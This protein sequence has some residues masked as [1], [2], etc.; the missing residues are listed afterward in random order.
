MKDDVLGV[1]FIGDNPQ[2][3]RAHGPRVAIVQAAGRITV[4]GGQSTEAVSVFRLSVGRLRPKPGHDSQE[5]HHHVLRTPASDGWYQTEK[6]RI[7]PGYDGG[8]LS[9][10]TDHTVRAE[11]ESS[12]A[13]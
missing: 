10:D 3:P 2:Y 8:Q 13:S 5:P 11:R 7:R 6:R 1:A 9:L 12:R 4:A